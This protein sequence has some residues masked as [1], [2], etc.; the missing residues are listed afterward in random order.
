MDDFGT[1]LRTM[2]EAAGLSLA[3]LAA[4]AK[5]SKPHLSHLENGQRP[6]SLPIVRA[7]DA[8]LSGGGVL[9]ELST[10]ERTGDDMRRRA[11]LAAVTAAAGVGTL[12][13]PHTVSDLVR[14]GLLD[15]AGT[16]ED[17][18]RIVDESASRLVVDP[19]PL[20]GVALLT[21][22]SLLRDKLTGAASPVLF[23]A[24]ARLGQIYGLWLGNL[25]HLGG[26]NHW[27]RTAAALADRSG[28]PATQVYARARSASRALYEGWTVRQ[29]LESAEVAL[30]VS[31]RPS[32]GALE[33]HA[34]RACVFALTGDRRQ[35]RAATGEMR[36]VADA[37]GDP[38]LHARTLAYSAFLECRI[39]NLTDA[40]RA[41]D[42]A[43]PILERGGLIWYQET[44]VYRARALVAA[45]DVE[46]GLG[47]ALEAVTQS[48]HDVRVVGVAVRDVLAALPPGHRSAERDELARFADPAPGP[49]ETLR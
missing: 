12:T 22:L 23:R 40:L 27:Y 48:R 24:A 1:A 33:A 11:L 35:G 28:D 31:E 25:G 42:E 20:F 17:W 7:I 49:W 41:C 36:R 30:T 2:R 8:A 6:P 19:S 4:K 9:I 45:G 44:R 3:A 13:G 46:A 15:A 14:H 32:A 37:V 43:E 34:A 39:G 5:V 16:D 29:T 26:A 18:D 38:D 47:C 10:A 21:N